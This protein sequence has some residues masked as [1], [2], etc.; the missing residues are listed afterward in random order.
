MLIRVDISA[1]KNISLSTDSA[2]EGEGEGG[3]PFVND[4]QSARF[5]K[6]KRQLVSCEKTIKTSRKDASHPIDAFSLF[7]KKKTI[8][9]I[10]TS[11]PCTV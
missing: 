6:L 1:S 7:V 2:E 3:E 4:F 8:F 9:F 10:P 11:V 5:E